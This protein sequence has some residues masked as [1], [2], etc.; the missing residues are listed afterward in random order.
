MPRLS[1]AATLRL[2]CF[3]R[4]HP[5]RTDRNDSLF[6]LVVATL[7][8]KLHDKD[9]EERRVQRDEFQAALATQLA[10]EWDAD[11]A[12]PDASRRAERE[13]WLA[14]KM[15]AGLQ[16]YDAERPLSK[17]LVFLSGAKLIDLTAEYLE[18][19]D[20]YEIFSTRRLLGTQSKFE[21]Q[22]ALR[23]EVEIAETGSTSAGM[24][25]VGRELELKVLE[26]KELEVSNV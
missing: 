11:I 16:E 7:V 25:T 2:E 9:K 20:S 5:V 24:R 1:Q 17:F 8:R 26:G 12:L 15:E 21:Q 14:R 19:N 13:A 18:Y 22:L 4:D 6:A 3:P 10:A 23:G